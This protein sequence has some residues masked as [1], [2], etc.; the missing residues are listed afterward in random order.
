MVSLKASQP[1]LTQIRQAIAQKGWKIGSARW[2]VE[3]SK[4]VEP[5]NDWQESGPYA[6]GCSAQTWE[7][8][9]QGIA[10]RDRSFIAFCQVLAINPEDITDFPSSLRED[11]GE[12][13]DV[14]T[15]H[16]REQELL[17]LEQWLLD[18]HCRLVT[19][20]G[21]AGVG[22]TRLIRGGIGKTDLSLQLARRVGRE[23]DCLIWRRLLSAPPLEALLTEL[24][25][26]VSDNQAIP[27]ETSSDG[28]M[29]QLL[30]QLKQH[31]C[32]LILDN[33]ESILQ[34]SVGE[35]P[36][37]EARIGV[38]RP[39]YEGY[40]DFFRRIGET[41]HQSCL[42][43]TSRE[44][45]QEIED[46]EGLQPVR[47]LELRGLDIA[48]GRAIFQDIGDAYDASF[49]G[50]EEE[51][52]ALIAFYNGNPLALEVA[53]R[54]ILKLFDGN[55]A[56]FL[57]QDLRV[58]GKI[59]DL[60]AWHFERFSEA[61]KEIMYWLAINR[62][63]VSISELR[64]DILSPFAQKRIPETL[65]TLERHIPVEKSNRR[66][67]LQPVLIEYMSDRFVKEIYQ[68]LQTSNLN[69][70]NRYALIKASAKDYVK[71]SQIRL[72]L[73]PII[74][75]V[76]QTL[77]LENKS[78][79]ESQLA[80]ILSNLQQT[81]QKRPG[82]AAGNLLNLMRY[83]GL[84]LSGYDFSTLAIWQ[85]NLQGVSLH[86]VN[87]AACQFAR[88]SFTQN[89][90][91]VHSIAFGPHQNLLA[92][93]DSIGG[94]RLFRL[95][96]EQPYAHLKG[97]KTGTITGISFSQDG[98]LLASSSMDSTVRLWDI[99]TGNCLKTL[100]GQEQWFW[101]VAVSPDGQTVASGGDNNTIRLWNIQTGDCQ[102]LEGH[103]A[104]VWSIAFHPQENIL[105]SGS[106]DST[107]RVWNVTTGE[108]RQI[109]S[110]HQN[111]VLTVNFH[112]NGETLVSGSADSTVK[113]WNVQTGDCLNTLTGHT[114]DVYSTAF[115]NDGQII[116]SGSF[117]RTAK[118]WSA[119]TGKLL[120]TLKGNILGIRT[121][122]FAPYENRLATGGD[123]QRLNL[124]DIETGKCLRNWRGYSNLIWS[125]AIS[126]D[127]KW[128]ASC[129]LD[130][131]VRLW[132]I[133]SGQQI[134]TLEGHR[135]VIETVAFSPN[136]QVLASGS[137]DKTIK[138]WD[139]KTGQC[140]KTL[141]SHA[142]E[143]VS[144]VAFSPNGQWLAS[145]GHSGK[146]H[147]WDAATGDGIRCIKVHSDSNW[148][149]AIA[150]S[151][152]GQTLASG[153]D[154][155]TIKLWD[156]ETGERCLTITDPISKI[157]TLA[158][159]PDG[160]RLASGGDDNQ[161]KLWDLSN[162]Q[163]IQT[164]QGHTDEVLGLLFSPDGDIIVSA[165]VDTTIRFWQV[166]TGQCI[167]TLEGHSSFV[168][169]LAFTPDG[170]TLASSSLDKTIR[171]WDME[172]GQTLKALRLQEPYEGMN[173][174]G[175]SGLTKAQKGTLISLGAKR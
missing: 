56:A 167:R 153:S 62:E 95:K 27:L 12:A 29:T 39:G 115:N 61:E 109:L 89:F 83:S 16:G 44:K 144:A 130:K 170:Q 140:Q 100:M 164:F 133:H 43:L 99:Q 123:D 35:T 18:D 63:A 58:F 147:L 31:R 117:D 5:Q 42:L 79:L 77:G 67:T 131:F 8:F 132:D 15:F 86:D 173:I 149:W 156:V 32:L 162:G 116:A 134:A 33:A 38:Y 160:Q 40:G 84:D 47:S 137:D 41:E 78:C 143:V 52:E 69:L 126:P 36:L 4:V 90:G 158:F 65:E 145:S 98:K 128:L 82:Y 121:L 159:H 45:P 125:I 106:F 161:I 53:A 171:F 76:T 154:D 139:I 169:G 87:F 54:H 166:S 168:R 110:G 102:V 1:G 165:S 111:S 163:L 135:N 68:E 120:K 103:T 57:A 155:K 152:D 172:T 72:I 148:V 97:H 141:H 37:S 50:T 124:W 142:M 2:L 13:P 81:Y 24:V 129:G 75:Q 175:A 101:T 85:A 107:V 71:E 66:F 151:P 22:K 127:G 88:S 80:Q 17:T 118:L 30:Q 138:L 105:A 51:W 104:W 150:F 19:I 122:A 113:V 73:R 112:P 21:L 92:M 64:E 25:D 59:R 60:L 114:Q 136:G 74:G 70:F 3:A 46:M 6:Y 55:L 93:G 49:Q 28:L 174:A 11:W 34:G 7:R 20:V 108:C 10:I 96:D 119:Q 26:F 14:P 146:V 157:M 94:I 91:N 48:A 23:F 9:L